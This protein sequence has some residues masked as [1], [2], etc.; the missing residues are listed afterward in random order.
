MDKDIL[1][2]HRLLS[3]GTC[4]SQSLAAMGLTCAGKEDPDLLAAAGC[5]CLGV[6]G[7]L[8]CGALSGAAMALSLVAPEL[9]SS[10]LVPE[11]SEWFIE[12]TGERFGGTDCSTILAGDPLNKA[13]RCPQ[14][15]EEVWKKTRQLLED[16][17]YEIEPC[18][19]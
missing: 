12:F 9:A 10:E 2:L 8:T 4:C 7:G 17:G 3:S 15:V 5:L 11:L 14:L 18:F 19:E 13:L 16:E 6:R 1:E